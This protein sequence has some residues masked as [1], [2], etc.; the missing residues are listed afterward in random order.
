MGQLAYEECLSVCV[1]YVSPCLFVWVSLVGVP[2]WLARADSSGSSVPTN[3]WDM[4][5]KNER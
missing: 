3:G 4:L 1:C 5:D 2:S